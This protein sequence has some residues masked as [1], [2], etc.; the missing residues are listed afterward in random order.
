MN[1]GRYY[2]KSLILAFCVVTIK[3]E[4]VKY[5]E[6]PEGYLVYCPCMGK[7]NLIDQFSDDNLIHENQQQVGLETKRIIS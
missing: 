5:E 2:L 3:S 7:S 1:A 6:D 4:G